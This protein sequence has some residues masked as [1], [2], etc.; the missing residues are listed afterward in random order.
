MYH[1]SKNRTAALACNVDPELDITYLGQGDVKK[2]NCLT[3]RAPGTYKLAED[4]KFCKGVAIC[5]AGQCITL[6]LNGHTIDGCGKGCVAVFVSGNSKNVKQVST[7]SITNGTIKNVRGKNCT[8]VCP[9]STGTPRVQARSVALLVENADNVIVEN[10]HV[11]QSDMAF[12]FK[13]V[14]N[15][16]I[17]A[18]DAVNNAG[19]GFTLQQVQTFSIEKTNTNTNIQ[20][21][22]ELIECVSGSLLD[23]ESTSDGSNGF[24]MRLCFAVTIKNSSVSSAALDGF[25]IDNCTNFSLCESLAQANLGLGVR[26]VDPDQFLVSAT[27]AIGNRLG[28]I[29]AIVSNPVW[30]KFNGLVTGCTAVSNG[31]TGT[32]VGLFRT[33]AATNIV[34]CGNKSFRNGLGGTNN[35]GGGA[36]DVLCTECPDNNDTVSL[37]CFDKQSGELTSVVCFDCADDLPVLPQTKTYQKLFQPNIETAQKPQYNV[38]RGICDT[39]PSGQIV[40]FWLSQGLTIDSAVVGLVYVLPPPGAGLT[41]TFDDYF[42]KNTSK[43]ARLASFPEHPNPSVG[44]PAPQSTNIATNVIQILVEGFFI[45]PT[46]ISGDFVLYN[47][48]SRDSVS[49]VY[50]GPYKQNAVLVSSTKWQNGL[51]TIGELNSNPDSTDNYFRKPLN[52]TSLRSCADG[53]RY[54]Y[55]RIYVSAIADETPH[56]SGPLVN[57]YL[58]PI[59]QG[60]EIPVQI[61]LG[62]ICQRTVLDRVVLSDTP[63]TLTDGEQ[64]FPSICDINLNVN[65]SLLTVF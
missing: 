48:V 33:L 43:G 53:T 60:E 3:L 65:E 50:A 14:T 32:S 30:D 26:I 62:P 54:G 12:Q 55:V 36:E 17:K 7:I 57:L 61:T 51:N 1:S 64:L 35:Y 15:L 37:P 28:G 31:S 42:K 4:V 20:G 29:S 34:F 19:V 46:R 49:G 58:N 45:V 5:I 6:D 9:C 13:T 52:K 22:Y 59:V 47:K 27:K 25:L 8:I 11:V 2:G 24:L 23:I 38:Y 16:F 18:C 44:T 56:I 10:I 40:H 63:P 21:G 39:F 41:V